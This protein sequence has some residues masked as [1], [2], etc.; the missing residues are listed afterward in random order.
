MSPVF[1]ILSEKV[2]SILTGNEYPF[3]IH[4]FLSDIWR[5]VK[6]AIRNFAIEIGRITSYNVCYTKL[7]R[8]QG[9]NFSLNFFI[10]QFDTMIK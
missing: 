9:T 1:A 5:G 4:Q 3:N 2:E 8:F 7:L 10:H 6:L